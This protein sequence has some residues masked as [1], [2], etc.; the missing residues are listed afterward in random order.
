MSLMGYYVE[1][2]YVCIYC[3]IVWYFGVEVVFDVEN[4]YNFVWKEMYDGEEVVVYCKGVMLVG[5][6][7]LG[8]ILGLMVDFVFFVCGKDGVGLLFLVSYGV[9]C[10]MSCM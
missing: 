1:V 3:L 9:G 2:N 4:Y 10:V 5:E 6:G 8:V 7:V